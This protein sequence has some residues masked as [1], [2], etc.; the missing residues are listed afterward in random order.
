MDIRSEVPVEIAFK[1]ELKIT[2]QFKNNPKKIER[3]P[4]SF[5]T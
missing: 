5:I 4:Y 1:F 3:K 2:I